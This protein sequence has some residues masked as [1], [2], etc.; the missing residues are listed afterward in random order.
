[1][2][3]SL[4]YNT[5]GIFLLSGLLIMI[6][7]SKN[8]SVQKIMYFLNSFSLYIDRYKMNNFSIIEKIKPLDQ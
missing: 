4:N 1:M 5:N 8:I 7:M 3:V 6:S 2:E